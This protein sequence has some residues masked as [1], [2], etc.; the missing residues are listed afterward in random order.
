MEPPRE[1]YVQCVDHGSQWS[2]EVYG[3]PGTQCWGNTREEFEARL[4]EGIA[5]AEGL[6][7]SAEPTLV[8][9]WPI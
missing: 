7:I 4:R 8:L 9:V 5:K 2:G 3:V 6:Q 1:Y